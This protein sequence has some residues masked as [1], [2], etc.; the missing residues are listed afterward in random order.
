MIHAGVLFSAS[1]VH[2]EHITMAL[3]CLTP[4]GIKDDVMI[5]IDK[6]GLSFSRQNNHVITISLFLSKELFISYDYHS[7]EDLNGY[8]Q[9]CLKINHLL[10]S[11]NVVNRNKDDVVE[12]TLSYNGEG[13][14]FTLIFED[15]LI[16]EKVEYS[17]YL[18]KE[19]DATGLEL[20]NDEVVFNCIIKGDV[21]YSAM[22]DLKEIGCRECYLYAMTKSDDKNVLALVSR[23]QLGLSKILLPSERS[24]LEKLEVIDP[25][26]GSRVFDVPVI[27]FFDFSAFD[28]VRMSAKIASKAMLKKDVHGLL[29]VNILSDTNDVVVNNPK[30]PTPATNR[31]TSL[32]RDYPGIVTEIALLERADFEPTDRKE[33]ELFMS[34]NE[35]DRAGTDVYKPRCEQ[36]AS[37]PVPTSEIN[38]T[39]LLHIGQAPSRD[40]NDNAA[41]DSFR[42][43]ANDIPLFF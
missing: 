1:T 7:G 38:D 11:I 43:A 19:P 35:E 13:S 17:T 26:T 28:K 30:G 6:D 32:P 5:Y 22:Q 12:C 9:L 31:N 34:F 39:N 20:S 27:G 4:F 14:P 33:I 15:S 21:L 10:D 41:D 23:G 40:D 29:S 2:L 3:N 25:D 36:A 18:T 24:T 42:P 16:T 8:T 37:K